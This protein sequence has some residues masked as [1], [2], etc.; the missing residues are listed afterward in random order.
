MTQPQPDWDSLADANFLMRRRLIEHLNAA[1]GAV[2]LID[3]PE[4]GAKPAD[5]W[6]SRAIRHIMRAQH[7]YEAWNLLIRYKAGHHVTR[8]HLFRAGDLL[9]W[10]ASE[11]YQTYSPHPDHDLLLIGNR[12]TLQEALLLVHS[13]AYS[14]GPGVRLHTQVKDDRFAF[15]VR[16]QAAKPGA[17][18]L[19]DLLEQL[20]NDWRTESAAYELRRAQDFLQMNDCELTLVQGDRCCELG[21]S[22][23][24]AGNARQQPAAGEIEVEDD[25]DITAI[26]RDEDETQP[27][28]DDI[29]ARF[30]RRV[31]A[32]TAKTTRSDK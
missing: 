6:K 32:N 22:V 20:V 8:T 28:G 13:A 4:G 12:E 23:A 15:R 21:F 24:T 10:L 14:L 5:F 16:Y 25:F 3:T 2:N 31:Q 1:V 30:S 7:L 17:Q 26:V 29:R 27:S 11:T 9:E 19:A 18:T